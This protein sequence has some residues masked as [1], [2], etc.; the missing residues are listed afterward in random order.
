MYK[1][2]IEKLVKQ[3][4]M[5]SNYSFGKE[6]MPMPNEI[7][8]KTKPPVY[9]TLK[10]VKNTKELFGPE[11]EKTPEENIVIAMSAYKKAERFVI[12]N[13][14]TGGGA[15]KIGMMDALYSGVM[16]AA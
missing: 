10:V 16:R 3:K 9:D 5:I 13:F 8:C 6:I 4:K 1:R 14:Y 2:P 11:P 12:V 7:E 15:H